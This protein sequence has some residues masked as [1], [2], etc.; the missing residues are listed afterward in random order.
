MFV[1]M[2]LVL[3]RERILQPRISMIAA[4]GFRIYSAVALLLCAEIANKRYSRI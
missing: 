4:R 1:A 3:L 2:L